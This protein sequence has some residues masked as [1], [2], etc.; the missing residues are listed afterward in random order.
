MKRNKMRI[1]CLLVLGATV[2]VCPVSATSLSRTG[3][4]EMNTLSGSGALSGSTL[5]VPSAAKDSM[6]VDSPFMT[7]SM[8]ILSM[9]SLT[10]ENSDSATSSASMAASGMTEEEAKAAYQNS[11]SSDGL[12]QAFQNVG[13]SILQGKSYSLSS[14]IGKVFSTDIPSDTLFDMSDIKTPS[15][16]DA[17]ALNLE[18]TSAANTLASNYQNSYDASGK[19]LNCTNL[20]NSL[21]GDLADQVQLGKVSIPSGFNPQQMLST[22]QQSLLKTYSASISSGEFANIKNSINIK[23]IFDK[24]RSGPS[25]YSLAS[26]KQLT[27]QM[28]DGSAAARGKIGAEQQ[29]NLGAYHKVNQSHQQALTAQKAQVNSL[30]NSLSML[31]SNGR[32]SASGQQ[33]QLKSLGKTADT[34][35]QNTLSK[36]SKEYQS[37]GSYYKKILEGKSG[38][39]FSFDSLGSLF[40]DMFSQVDLSGDAAKKYYDVTDW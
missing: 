11:S 30:K 31:K 7:Q 3:G 16:F 6:G 25:S 33:K 37:V 17:G 12:S 8:P 4:M 24:A 35:G 21:Y 36:L 32:I 26:A 9:P 19:S 22:A 10:E 5:S 2:A 1:A 18:F 15:W 27:S 13:L 20:F 14:E 23:S 29:I 38:D 40:K 34:A 28:A 39:G